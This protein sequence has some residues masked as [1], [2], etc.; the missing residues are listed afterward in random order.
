MKDKKCKNKDCNR[1]ISS[2][3]S[4]SKLCTK[5]S[6]KK[7]NEEHKE[8]ISIYNK[9]YRKKYYQENKA[10]IYRISRVYYANHR[11]EMDK[12][13]RKHYEKNIET[14]KTRS[15]RRYE[16]NKE[17]RKAQNLEYYHKRYKIDKG[18]RIRRRLG[19]AL[20]HVIRYYI[21]T[22]KVSNPMKK[23]GLDW[24]GI[25]RQ[26]T[27]IPKPRSKYQ[28]DHIIPLFRF[29]LTDFEQ[30]QIAFAPENHRWMLAKDNMRR[31]KNKRTS[32]LVSFNVRK[33]EKYK[34]N[35]IK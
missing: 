18:F 31:N 6:Q 27:P 33:N 9:K 23:Y 17:L 29:D 28:V 22:G 10:E 34:N 3:M 19:T 1:M 5:C 15:K 13:K 20:G 16:D 8:E 14:F 21:K 35:V 2:K 4:K 25:I 11:K 24:K 12:H 7:W 26:L 30:V 32:R